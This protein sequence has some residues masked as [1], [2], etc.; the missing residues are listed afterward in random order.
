MNFID[1]VVIE[2]TAG[3]GGNGCMS[4]RREKNLPRGGPDGGDGGKGGSIFIRAKEGLNTLYD[5]RHKEKF[6]A[7]DGSKGQ[8]RNRSG[9][10]GEDLVIEV[11]CGTVIYDNLIKEEII[12]LK[13]NLDEIEIVSGGKGGNGNAKYKSSKNRSPKKIT[14]G[15]EGQERSL[16]MELKVLADV[17]LLGKPNAGK[18]SLVKAMSNATPKIADYEF[19]TLNP[20]LGVVSLSNYASFVIS[21][22]PGLIA[23]ASKGKGIGLK[24]LKHLSRT[25]VILLVVDIFQKDASEVIKEVKL[26]TDELEAFDR[27][28]TKRLGWLVLNKIDLLDKETIEEIVQELE[29]HFK[30]IMKIYAV[31]ATLK[32]RTDYLIKDLGKFLGNLHEKQ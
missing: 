9:S 20:T 5:F 23:G 24:F 32:K 14:K 11:P 28:L 2:V 15:S 17:G 30:K 3:K 13:G 27:N 22:I 8:S 26:L 21:D 29:T 19:T 10:D 6:S 12:D 18:S 1:E 31:S 16:R 7:K 25:K 4:F